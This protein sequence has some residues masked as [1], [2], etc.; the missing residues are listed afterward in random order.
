MYWV[1]EQLCL[2]LLVAEAACAAS[3]YWKQCAAVEQ[4]E[5]VEV[6]SCTHKQKL[7]ESVLDCSWVGKMQ[8][9]TAA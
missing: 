6:K 7:C 5:V 4:G 8:L 9:S 2:Q 1:K 3:A